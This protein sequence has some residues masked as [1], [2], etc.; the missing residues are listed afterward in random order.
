MARSKRTKATRGPSPASDADGDEEMDTDDANTENEDDQ[1]DDPQESAD[2]GAGDDDDVEDVVDDDSADLQREFVRD[3]YKAVIGLNRT[4]SLALYIDENMTKAKDF[5]R[6]KPE[7]IEKICVAIRKS[8]KT[9]IPITA[10][11]RLSL[12]AYYVKHQERTSHDD[13][14]SGDDLSGLAHHMEVE[15]NWD[16]KH[17]IPDTTRP[18]PTRL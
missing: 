13:K 18:L 8:H 4:A 12:L 10:M 6:V 14:W 1:Q 2:N 5:L 15:L 7:A 17:K 3:F 11:D 16:K 9:S